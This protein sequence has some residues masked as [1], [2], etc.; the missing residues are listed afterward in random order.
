MENRP[1]KRVMSHCPLCYASRPGQTTIY[2]SDPDNPRPE[3]RSMAWFT[4]DSENPIHTS[5][6]WQNVPDFLTMSS[7]EESEEEDLEDGGSEDV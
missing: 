1:I 6:R 2:T 4:P 3:R 7:D 5:E